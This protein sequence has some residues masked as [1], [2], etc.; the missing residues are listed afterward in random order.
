VPV[1]NSAATAM[2]AATHQTVAAANPIMPVHPVLGAVGA[3][4]G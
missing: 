2:P 3:R 4:P 1:A